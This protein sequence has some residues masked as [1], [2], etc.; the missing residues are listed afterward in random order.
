MTNGMIS[1]LPLLTSA[2]ALEYEYELNCQEQ[3][4][5]INSSENEGLPPSDIAL[6][7]Y[8]FGSISWHSPMALSQFSH[9]LGFPTFSI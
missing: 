1:V 2:L 8:R 9:F 3:L 6:S 7:F 5:L 4:D